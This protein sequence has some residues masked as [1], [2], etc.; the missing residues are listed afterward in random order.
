M[1][2]ILFL[3]K[4]ELLDDFPIPTTKK[5]EIITTFFFHFDFITFFFLKP[6]KYPHLI[7]SESVQGSIKTQQK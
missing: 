3:S 1:Y 6:R 2:N 5:R 4:Y 7:I